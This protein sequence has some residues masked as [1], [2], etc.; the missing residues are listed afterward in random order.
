M[1]TGAIERLPLVPLSTRVTAVMIE[2]G[3]LKGR[4]LHILEYPKSGGTWLARMLATMLEW[5]FIDDSPIPPGTACV[6]RA[7]ALPATTPRHFIYLARDPRDVYVSFFHHRIQHW[8]TNKYYR[9]AWLQA[10]PGPLAADRIREQMRD[11]ILFETLFAGKRGAAT[12]LPWQAHVKE[13]LAKVDS[14]SGESVGMFMTYEGLRRNT[15]DEL[16]RVYR[17]LFNG[18]CPRELASAVVTAH[19]IG[20]RRMMKAHAPIGRSIP[21]TGH[22]GGWHAAFSRSA[23]QALE[24][25]AGDMMRRLNYT[26]SNDWWESLS[27]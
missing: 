7:H 18:E 12:P 8:G 1:L 4:T 19:D 6:L 5:P 13:G 14:N 17:N 24:E 20:L 27:V 2:R 23:G 3:Y 9:E 16:V 11:F 26:E 25:T 21:R 15:E 22:T 10:H